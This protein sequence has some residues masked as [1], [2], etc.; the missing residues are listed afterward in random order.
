ML[1]EPIRVNHLTLR[2]R[3][4]MPPMYTGHSTADGTVPA[5]MI[6]YY[7]DRAKSRKIGLVFLEH[8]YVSKQ[9]RAG[10][11]QVSLAEDA[12]TQGLHDL[13]E[14]LHAAETPIFA[15]L[16]HGGSSSRA[17]IT[18]MEVIGPSAVLNPGRK[19]A[20]MPR[21]MTK[22]EILSIEEDFLQAALRA[23]AA[24]FDG[25]E[26][27]CAHSYG[28][29][30]FYSPLSNH[31]TDEYG[32]QTIENRTRALVETYRKIRSKVGPDYPIAVRLGGC[33]YREGGSTI[34]DAV[35]ACR[36]FEKEGFDLID[37]SGGM[38]NYILPG[39]EEPGYFGDMSLAVKKAV[40]IPVILT[41]GFTT[42]EQAEAFLKKG[43]A[44]C[45]GVGRALLKDA[46]WAE[47]EIK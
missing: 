3:L 39:H 22:E 45:I 18:G 34:E 37:L 46:D 6:A 9:G 30:Q 47:R 4:V 41:G 29:N 35:A 13:V 38:C 2:S 14:H 5:E 21:E 16:N 25:I 26:L 11:K 42:A 31:R 1:N 40:S 44:D 43:Y 12:D 19:V 28:F 20:D 32:P 15:Q 10:D 17:E 33:D 8:A 36:L 23:K 7:Y 27:H 24:G